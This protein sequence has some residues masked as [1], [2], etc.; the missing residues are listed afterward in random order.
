MRRENGQGWEGRGGDPITEPTAEDG[1]WEDRC[2]GPEQGGW[3]QGG[4][5]KRQ[6]RDRTA[7]E[8]WWVSEERVEAHGRG[9]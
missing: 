3:I 1:Y 5:G 2:V 4:K 7:E 9:N 8:G 6:H